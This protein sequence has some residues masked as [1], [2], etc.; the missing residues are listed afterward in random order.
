MPT[1]EGKRGQ[2]TK[3]GFLSPL[4]SPDLPLSRRIED[5]RLNGV[6]ELG[7]V[8]RADFWTLYCPE[9]PLRKAPRITVRGHSV[10]NDSVPLRKA[11][12]QSRIVPWSTRRPC[13]PLAFRRATEGSRVQRKGWGVKRGRETL[14]SLPLLPP[15]PGGGNPHAMPWRTSPAREGHS[16]LQRR[17]AVSA[18]GLPSSD[19]KAKGTP[20]LGRAYPILLTARCTACSARFAACCAECR[21]DGFSIALAATMLITAPA[22]APVAT[23]DTNGDTCIL[24]PPF[25]A[26]FQRR[27]PR[28]SLIMSR[29]ARFLPPSALTKSTCK[30][31]NILR[32]RLFTKTLTY[33]IMIENTVAPF[34]VRFGKIRL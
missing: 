34:T 13:G 5:A 9:F 11:P 22:T 23:P 31:R 10:Q 6:R 16:R 3:H 21:S 29:R 19:G 28:R 8:R 17:A 30:I 20:A 1:A 26:F 18:E 12:L 15:P 7:S 32:N 2:D 27:S 24:L 4:D 33:S 25:F 14:V